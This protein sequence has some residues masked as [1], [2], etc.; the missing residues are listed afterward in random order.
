MGLGE[1]AVD[2]GGALEVMARL[3]EEPHAEVRGG[4]ARADSA[5]VRLEQ[6]GALERSAGLAAALEAVQLLHAEPALVQRGRLARMLS[7]LRGGRGGSQ[8]RDQGDGQAENRGMVA[9]RHDREYIGRPRGWRQRSIERGQV[10]PGGLTE[11]PGFD[12]MY[13]A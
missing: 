11:A 4:P 9:M 3:P 2:L 12:T 8:E 5:R 13:D 6:H 7:R 1:A 10:R